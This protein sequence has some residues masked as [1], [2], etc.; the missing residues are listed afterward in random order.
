MG[1]SGQDPIRQ[2]FRKDTVL[3]ALS[4]SQLGQSDNSA[5]FYENG[6]FSAHR[7]GEARRSGSARTFY[8][9]ENRES[10]F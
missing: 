5:I 7:A 6:F 3:I 2:G 1:D 10:F 9:M 4:F 8:L